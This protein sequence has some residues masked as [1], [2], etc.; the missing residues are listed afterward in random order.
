[1]SREIVSGQEIEE[2]VEEDESTQIAQKFGVELYREIS[3]VSVVTSQWKE[4]ETYVLRFDFD[5]KLDPNYVE[6]LKNE[7]L[8]ELP[9]NESTDNSSERNE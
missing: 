3:P 9:L 7:K 1:M 6:T 2:I 8:A 5:K 4:G